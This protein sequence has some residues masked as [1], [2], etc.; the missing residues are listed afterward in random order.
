M[1]RERAT[2][3]RSIRL[4]LLLCFWFTTVPPLKAQKTAPALS[5][6]SS[7]EAFVDTTE[8]LG[9]N[10]QYRASHTSRKY[11][12]ETMGPGVALFD[13]TIMTDAWT[14]IW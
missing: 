3:K 13:F 8:R 4:K 7:V 6:P 14:F 1:K 2:E 9:V 10:F 11:L 5:A 12:V